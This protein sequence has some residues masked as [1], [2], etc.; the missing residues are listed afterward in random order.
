LTSGTAN[1]FFFFFGRDIWHTPA[2]VDG[3][4]TLTEED[5]ESDFLSLDFESL[6]PN[7][8]WPIPAE[9]CFAG[10]LDLDSYFF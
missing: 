1:R 8:N 7:Y 4:R 5:F 6:R 10:D 3:T 9:G 2:L